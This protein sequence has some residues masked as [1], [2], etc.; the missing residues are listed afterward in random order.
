MTSGN[1]II[2]FQFLLF[3]LFLLVPGANA[4][5][6]IGLVYKKTFDEVKSLLDSADSYQA[7]GY[8]NNLGEPDS[9]AGIYSELV[10]DF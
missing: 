6:D 1:Y 8:I 10:I 2:G 3:V 5:D 4:D 7:I 9:V